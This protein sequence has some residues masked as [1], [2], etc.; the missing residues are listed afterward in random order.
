MNSNL[1]FQVWVKTGEVDSVQIK[2]KMNKN[3]KKNSLKSQATGLGFLGQPTYARVFILVLG[4]MTY[5]HF[6]NRIFI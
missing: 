3:M 2:I 5:S 6:P 1:D 4:S